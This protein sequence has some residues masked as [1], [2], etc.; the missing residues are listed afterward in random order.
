MTEV[1]HP[2]VLG[3]LESA[4]EQFSSDGGNTW[5]D[6]GSYYY[7]YATGGNGLRLALTPQDVQNAGGLSAVEGMSYGQLLPYAAQAFQYDTF[8]RVSQATVDGLYAY[9]Y[10]YTVTTAYNGNANIWQFE[11]TESRPDGSSYSVY[12]NLMGEPVLT[13]LADSTGNNWY[14]AWTYGTSGSRNGL[15]TQEDMP[16][17]I[18]S[19]TVDPGSGTVSLTAPDDGQPQGLVYDYSYYTSGAAGYLYQTKLLNGLNADP[20]TAVL[21]DQDAY[22]TQSGQTDGIA[23]T[24]HPLA[25]ETVY[26]T[27]GGSGNTTSYAYTW[28][29]GTVQEQTASTTLPAVPASENGSAASTPTVEFYDSHGKLT[30]SEDGNGNVTLNQY[31]AATGLLMESV[32]NVNTSDL[33]QA[34]PVRWTRWPYRAISPATR[35]L[36]R[37]AATRR[38]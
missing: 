27:A 5:S 26:P 24:V 22:A 16:S 20:S 30:W 7:A 36:P 31:D 25:A 23:V 18:A 2:P 34:I 4:T 38:I 29:P 33:P 14:T 21:V 17:S 15:P 28:Y 11:T 19:A 8:N 35:S 12:T 3:D 6:G 37:P 13:D 10:S 1:I 32:Q 9:G